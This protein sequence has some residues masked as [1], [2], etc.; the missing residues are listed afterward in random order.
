MGV[1]I[2]Y[3][4][5]IADVQRVEDFED[6]VIDLVL[7]LGGNVRVWRSADEQDQARMVRGLMVD[8]APGQE[9]TSLLLSPEGW[10][11]NLFEI[12]DAEKGRLRETPWCFIKTQF[13]SVDGHVALVE[14]LTAL[15]REFFP[16][17][18]VSDE[19]GYWERRDVEEL[20]QKMAFVG[21]AIDTLAETIS[22]DGL[23]REAA[24]DPQILA[25]RIE[26]LA[27]RVHATISRPA[28]HAPV[29]FPE[30]ET[31]ALADPNENE[32]RWDELFR[33]NRRKQERM[34][35][36]L[37]EQMA[38]GADTDEAFEAAIEEVV[39]PLDWFGDNSDKSVDHQ[40]VARMEEGDEL[41]AD[42]VWHSGLP[43]ESFDDV[44]SDDDSFAAMQRDPLQQQATDR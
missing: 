31:G 16:D 9:T 37:E 2:H 8:L 11:V 34:T 35:R 32:A 22:V 14:L 1:T 10:L 19:G 26:R 42:D 13:G 29:Y 44:D 5:R 4:G 28:E 7:E 18:E 38:R 41:E 3:R 6:R 36:T 17:L 43:D 40:Y 15:K 25:T 23:S 12:E 27:H 30:D 20:R 24:E 39:A 33:S 21:R